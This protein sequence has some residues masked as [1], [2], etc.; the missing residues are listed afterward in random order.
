MPTPQPTPQHTPQ[1][2]QRPRPGTTPQQDAGQVA[3]TPVPPAAPGG[4]ALTQPLFS[5]DHVLEAVAAGQGTLKQGARG[6][7]VRALQ[8]FLLGQGIQVGRSGA[9]GV[10]GDATTKAVRS[11]QAS[12]GLNPDAV[13]GKDT[14]GAMDR[15]SAV[16]PPSPGTTTPATAPAPSGQTP[17]PPTTQPGPAT[18]AQAQGGNGPQQAPPGS[19]NGGLPEDFQKMWDAHPHNY[20]T[21]GTQNTDSGDLQVQQGWNPDTYSNTCA[22]R[23]SIML[24]KLGGPLTIT[25][26]KA[27]AAGIDPGRVPFSKKTGWYYLLAAKE[28]WTFLEFH[29]GK[30]HAEFPARG[31][32]ANAA[33]FQKTFDEEIQP[34]VASKRGI[35]AFDKIFTFSGTGHVDIFDGMQLSDGNW[36][37]SQALKLWFV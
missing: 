16:S 2:G 27:K 34:L 30:P 5:G 37:P 4:G 11:W 9:D 23:L 7:S 17:R 8:N 25:R 13:V 19:S 33:Q 10:W 32:F 6:P 24:N 28:M 35:V 18:P 15:Q 21:D 12:H 29:A 26:E 14:L 3:Q 36:Y 31:R 1:Q 22:I 20:Q